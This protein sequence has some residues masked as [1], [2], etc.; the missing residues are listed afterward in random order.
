MKRRIV[1]ALVFILA[2]GLCGGLV[3]FNFFRDKMITQFFATMQQ[4]PQTVSAAKVEAKTWTPSISAI[5]TAKAA[6]GVE[7]AFEIAGIVSEIKFKANQNV[8]QGEVL[9]Q[10]DDTVERADIQD[11]Q[12]NVKTA[13]SSFERAKT[14]STRGYGTEAN[15]DQASALLAAARSRLARLQAMIE[16]KALKAPFSGVI[17]IPRIDVGQ[18]LQPGTVIASFQ[19]L[20]SMKVDFTVPEQRAG[21]I[22]LGQEVRIGTTEGNLPFK[23]R[24]TG[25][26]PRVDPKTRL[27][28][29]QALVEDNKDGAVLPGQFLHVEV[30][31][32]EQPNVMTVPQTAVIASLY[33]DYVYTIDQEEKQ[34]Q[35]VQVVKQVF[36]KTGRRR[37]GALEIVSGVNPGQQVVASGQNKLQSGATVKIDNSIDVTKF[38]SSKLA[39]G[40]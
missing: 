28:S 39:S 27:V 4:P 25:K 19:D 2:I 18:Y 11:V 10:L 15:L 22:N 3:W 12:A 37:G 6:N 8:K 7:L 24:V 16:Q 32:P 14:L 1:V 13:E 34:G 17:G 29:V 9:V 33:G 23:G 40:Q 21:E 38:E 26:D 20:S 35:Q 5:G 31:L 30:I 36:V